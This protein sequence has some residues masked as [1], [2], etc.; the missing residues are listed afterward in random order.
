MVTMANG[1]NSDGLGNVRDD[2]VSFRDLYALLEFVVLKNVPFD[3]VLGRPT[4]KRLEGVLEFRSE[5]VRL[6]CHGHEAILPVLSEHLQLPDSQYGTGTEGFTSE[7]SDEEPDPQ[8][9]IAD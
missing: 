9:R 2:P 3:L 7:L 6:A 1:A 4:L 8:R 5:E